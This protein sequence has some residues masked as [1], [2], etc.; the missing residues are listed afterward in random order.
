M[1]FKSIGLGKNFKNLLKVVEFQVG[2]FLCSL[3]SQ[4]RQ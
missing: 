4:H 3:L 2:D 1:A